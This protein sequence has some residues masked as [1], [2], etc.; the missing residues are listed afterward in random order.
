[1]VAPDVDVVGLGA[2]GGGVGGCFP[3]ARRPA[4][5]PPRPP[6]GTDAG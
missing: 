6:P 4:A 2:E 1:L 5:L 3:R